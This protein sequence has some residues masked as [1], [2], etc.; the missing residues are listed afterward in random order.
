MTAYSHPAS[1][2]VRPQYSVQAAIDAASPGDMVEVLAGVYDENIVINKPIILRGIFGSSAG[3]KPVLNAGG[4][5]GIGITIDADGV[6]VDGFSITKRCQPDFNPEGAGIWVRSNDIT[7]SNSSISNFN[8]GISLHRSGN[9]A[10]INNDICECGYGIT[11]DRS[12]NNTIVGNIIHDNMPVSFP[13]VEGKAGTGLYLRSSKNNLIK[14]NTISGNGEG[15]V[16]IISGNN[17]LKGNMVTNNIQGIKLENFSTDNIIVDGDIYFNGFGLRIF[18]SNGNTIFH[19]NFGNNYQIDVYDDGN[20]LWDNGAIGNFY[21]EFACQARDGRICG[22]ARRIAGG[23]NADRYPLA[24]EA[25][26]R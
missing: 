24:H 15:I 19:N 10:V 2:A 6:V 22:Y 20:N 14:D 17:L 3:T 25:V 5:N 13:T 4:Q 26:S 1:Y 21:S 12:D 23:A 16:L 8:T 7:I 11:L 18:G 9:N